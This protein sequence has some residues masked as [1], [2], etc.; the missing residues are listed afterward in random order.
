MKLTIGERV[1]DVELTPDGVTVDGE[2]FR[3]AVDGFGGTRIVTVNGR[4][5]RLD[6]GAA[7]DGVTPVTVDGQT[8][9]ARLEGSAAARPAAV[10]SEASPRPAGAA[11]N[12]PPVAV[13]GAVTA[14]MN[15]RIVRIGVQA[16][17]TVAAGDL[18]L[19]LEAMKMENEIRA[20]RGGTVKELLVAAGDRVNKGAPLLVIDE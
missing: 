5:V 19:I 4:P 3:T 20:P 8:L 13:K 14:S 11:R 10:R 6:L 18:L 2:V 16:G 7:A 17:G 9:A 1:Y 15:G 12:A